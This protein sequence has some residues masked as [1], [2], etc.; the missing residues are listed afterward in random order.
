MAVLKRYDRNVTEFDLHAG[1]GAPP[2]VIEPQPRPQP[3]ILPGQVCS[4]PRDRLCDTCLER[5]L[6][7]LKGV[8]MRRA[9]EWLTRVPA[10]VR[11][12]DWPGYTDKV[13]AIAMRWVADLGDDQQLLSMLAAEFASWAAKRWGWLIPSAQ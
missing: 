10:N 11:S 3:V 2:I 8:A 12:R 4:C 9:D 7:C 5:N 6:S 1:R 13:A